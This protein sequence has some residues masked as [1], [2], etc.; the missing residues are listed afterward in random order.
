MLDKIIEALD[1]AGVYIK[2]IT[3]QEKL[4]DL[5]QDS[6]TY[7]TFVLEIERIFDVE[8]DEDFYSDK[9]FESTLVEIVEVLTAY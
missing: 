6:L 1:N 4:G 7:V 5:I 3:G 2:D 8:L 9:V